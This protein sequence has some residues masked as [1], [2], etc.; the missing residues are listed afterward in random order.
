MEAR[1][2]I[3]GR[4]AEFAHHYFLGLLIGA[5]A[6]AAIAPEAGLLARHMS[7]GEVG[8]FGQRAVVSLPS[9]M[10]ALL[11][12]NA[13]LGAQP[14]RIRRLARNPLVLG[15]GLLANLA[16]P[17]L[18]ILGMS[19]TLQ[20]WHN[21]AE[22]QCILV[23]LALI[24]SMPVAGS[25]TAWSQNAN[26]DLVLS[27]GLV[28]LSTCLSPLTTPAVLHAAGWVASG[29]YA[30]ALRAL[31]EGGTSFFLTA[32]VMLPSFAGIGTRIVVGE[33]LL[34]R[35]RP[36]LKL[37]NSVNLL[38]LCYSNAAVALPGVVENPDWD[39]MAVMLVIV[40]GLCVI[41]FASGWAVARGLRADD[42]QRT[43]LMF[44][45]GMTN[46]GTG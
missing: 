3:V 26:G 6:V 25:S 23:G 14:D 8:V 11:L 40:L 10:L 12:F 1:Q 22:V 46:N 44:G 24:A 13:G 41:G 18:F 32:F 35:I 37:T 19:Q 36:V 39:F 7:F 42:G 16:V 15:A 21:P 38:V 34:L 2:G 4:A 28:I 20:V 5:Y 27:L 33:A 43:S 29:E 9:V 17:L 31:S 45:L 30:D